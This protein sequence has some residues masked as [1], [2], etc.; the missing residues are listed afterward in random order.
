MNFAF[1]DEQRELRDVA[2]RFLQDTLP[3]DR[4]AA[5]A[6]SAEG[7]DPSSWT[8]LADM[9]WLGA[10]VAEDL[11]GTGLGYIE[12][13]ILLEE[14]GRALYAG[15]YLS[16]ILALPAL[17]PDQQASVAVGKA[18]WS[19][20]VDGL[21][22]DLD[23]VDCVV[24]VDG[25]MTAEGEMLTSIDP[26]RPVG[27]L[28]VGGC[29]PLPG[30]TGQAVVLSALAS[31]ALG[32]ACRALEI[33]VGYVKER[34]QFGKAIG[35]YQGISHPLADT[36]SD[37]ELARSLVYAA[38]WKLSAEPDGALRAASIAKA[39][40]TEVAVAATERAIQVHGGIGF[41]WEHPLH[42]F[43]KRALWLQ[44]FAGYP[45]ELRGIVRGALLPQWVKR[46]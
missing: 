17:G 46:Q 24:T 44:A 5:I 22:P 41:T 10:T 12:Q 20:E 31:E 21:V 11:G 13:A 25:A 33:G 18:R 29:T 16:T 2:R 43:Y 35:T 38:A 39:F 40:A 1:T 30:T 36:F 27:R 23:R 14:L 34:K 7:W 6:D 8:D 15:P 37:I 26:T 4:V 3:L 28:Q 9:G 42:R 45:S 19:V 32:V